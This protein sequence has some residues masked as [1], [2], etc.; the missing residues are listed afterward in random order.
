MSMTSFREQLLTPIMADNPV[1]ERLKDDPQLNFIDSQMMKVGSLAHGEVQWEKVEKSAVNLLSTKSK[2]I[3]LLTVLIQCLQYKPTPERFTLSIGVLVDFISCFWLECQ[4][5]P[6][7]RGAVHRKKFFNQICQRTYVAADKLDSSLFDTELKIELETLLQDLYLHAEKLMLPVDVVDDINARLHH[8]LEKVNSTHKFE[9]PKAILNS[10]LDLSNNMMAASNLIS[11]ISAPIPNLDIDS[12][13]DRNFKISLLKAVECL[14]DLGCDGVMLSIRIRRFAMWYS[15]QSL[16]DANVNG[17]TQLM[18]VLLDRISDYEEGLQRGADIE[19]WRRV[20][21]SLTKAPYWLDGHFLSYRIATALGKDS[22]SSIIKEELQR[23]MQRLPA[24]KAYSFKGG[25][26]FI[27]ELTLKWLD[28][29]VGNFNIAEVNQ[30]GC[31][32]DK[33]NE[34]LVLAQEEGIAP[35]LQ[36]L[37]EGLS[38]AT[39]PRDAFYWR[40]LSA[41]VM[42]ANSLTA[43]AAEQYQTLHHQVNAMSVTEWEPALIKQIENNIAA[44]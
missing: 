41:D 44:E 36:M 37:N 7:E 27:S 28:S 22:W 20:E 39:E 3:K 11:E 29:S 18:P 4:P 38:Q 13:N 15:I 26:P 32:N 6:G 31:W 30:V 19:L 12:S 34:A 17:E 40:L 25:V 14:S 21:E 5:R 24:L 1:G 23:F 35:S 42:K 16:P 8:K 9:T 43:M 33:R 2:D 10:G